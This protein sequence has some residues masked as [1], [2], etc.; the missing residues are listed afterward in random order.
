M[1]LSRLLFVVLISFPLLN[2]AGWHGH[3][4]KQIDQQTTLNAS[5]PDTIHTGWEIFGPILD[6]LDNTNVPLRLPSYLAAEELQYPHQLYAD[7]V[8]ISSEEYVVQV[9]TDTGCN[10]ARACLDGIMSGQQISSFDPPSGS[11]TVS[12]SNGIQGYYVPFECNAYCSMGKII[13]QENGYKYTVEQK[14]G[15]KN[16]MILIANSAIESGIG[17]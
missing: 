5:L 9:V 16:V 11:E 6:N 8:S 12:L 14:A 2:F 13:W 4:V 15:P 7:P 3:P 17:N 10:G 1:K